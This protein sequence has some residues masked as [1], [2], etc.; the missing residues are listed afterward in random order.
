MK[1][2][3]LNNL[4]CLCIGH[5]PMESSC[6]FTGKTYLVCLRCEKTQVIE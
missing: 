3:F 1:I 6:P 5:K 4:T 2:Q